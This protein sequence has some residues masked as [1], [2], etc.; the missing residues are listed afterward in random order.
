VCSSD[1]VL[2]EGEAVLARNVIGDSTL[3]SRDSKGEIHALSVMCAPVRRGA[4]IIGL[5]HLYSTRPERI[6]DPDDLEFTLAVADT[7]GVAL[8]NL[9]RR[10]E[11]AENLLQVRDENVQLRQRLAL[12]HQPRNET[13]PPKNRP[14]FISS[15]QH[16]S[17]PKFWTFPKPN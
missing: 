4:R 3:T 14:A 9:K 12:T 6:P 10:Q 7:V 1:L 2:R 15:E 11:L 13:M 16:T 8:Q 5:I 17:Q